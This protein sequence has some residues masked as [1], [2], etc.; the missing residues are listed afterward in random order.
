MQEA[1]I[2]SAAVG[3][4]SCANL[5]PARERWY[6]CEVQQL[7]T[8]CIPLGPQITT[9]GTFLVSVPDSLP[10]AYDEAWIKMRA[11]SLQ[12]VTITDT[13]SLTE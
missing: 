6:Q 3:G 10:R 5:P 1:G 8:T 2:I 7:R 9:S 11:W 13:K 12:Q 4:A